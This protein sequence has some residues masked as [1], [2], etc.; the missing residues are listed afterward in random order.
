[1]VGGIVVAGVSVGG[2]R[3]QRPPA[4]SRFAAPATGFDKMAR[5]FP[6]R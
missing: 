6:F 4:F 3:P 2:L 1:M 5:T